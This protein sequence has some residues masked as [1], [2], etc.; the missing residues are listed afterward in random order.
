MGT[1]LG[2]GFR[3][4][5]VFFALEAVYGA[6]EQEHGEGDND[7]VEQRIEEQAV[8]DRYGAGL[9][10]QLEGGVGAGGRTGLQDEVQ[11]GEVD[12][13][14]QQADGRGDDVGDHG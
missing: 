9:L 3:R 6:D 2:G 5:G 13:A 8:I 4:W 1:I 14:E 12:A 11:V 10:S 7:E